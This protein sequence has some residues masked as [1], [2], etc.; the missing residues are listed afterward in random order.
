MRTVGLRKKECDV[1]LGGPPCQGFSTHRIN[2]EGVDDPRNGLLLRYFEFVRDLNPK[3]FVVE[4]VPGLL[5]KRHEKYLKKFIKEAKKSGYTVLAPTTLNARDY[6]V[7]QNRKRVFIVGIRNDVKLNLQWPPSPT[8][9]DPN[10]DE[11]LLQK[12]PAW[13]PAKYVFDQR[14]SKTDVNAIHM[15]HSPEIVELFRRTP[16]N[17]G[18]RSES[19]RECALRRRGFR[20]SFRWRC[21]ISV[22]RSRYCSWPILLSRIF[23]ASDTFL[24]SGSGLPFSSVRAVAPSLPWWPHAIA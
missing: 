12:L 16:K 21:A 23:P 13:K 5:W 8:H 14:L 19:G 10:S 7:P 11:V 1:L 20:K 18:S 2:D 3:A 17:G 15:N 24:T 22:G 6:G 4:N 9:F